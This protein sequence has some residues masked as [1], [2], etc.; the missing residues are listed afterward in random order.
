VPRLHARTI[1]APRKYAAS[2]PFPRPS[3]R[4]QHEQPENIMSIRPIRRL[5]LAATIAAGI[6]ALATAPAFA[7]T[8]I[9]ET[10]P[11]AADGTVHVE[12]VKGRV[13]VRTWAQ[14][15]VRITGSLG[16]G[17]EK[18]EIEGGTR[19]LSISVKYPERGGWKLW[20]RD[21]GDIE[22]TVL[23]VMV[24]NR[25]SLDLDT[26]SADIDVQQMA[27]RQLDASS[28]SGAVVVTASSP[29]E[30]DVESV[31]G[32]VI[33]RITTAKLDASTVSGDVRASGGITGR[34]KLESVS[35]DLEL[36]AQALDRLEVSTVSGDVGVRTAL[37]PGGSIKGETLSGELTL[38]LPASSSARVHVESFS[39]DIRSPSGKVDREEHGPG[40]SLETQFGSGQGQ[41]EL[42]SFSGD[43]V[44]ELR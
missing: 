32:D 18:L 36:G 22:P 39:G 9:N 27:G 35:G 8:P 7:A 20:S 10:R 24:P 21:D 15:Q 6:A 43:V 34:V 44:I 3:H 26:V 14:P 40:S 29:G 2:K 41:I 42:E 30:A 33:L 19:S 16:K 4:I 5:Q 13:V 1:P 28:V 17:A 31:S 12:N 38:G 37:R 11:L 25:A 23:E